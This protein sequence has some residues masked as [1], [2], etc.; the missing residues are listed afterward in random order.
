MPIVVQNDVL[1]PALWMPGK[2]WIAYSEKGYKDNEWRLSDEAKD[3]TKLELFEVS[4]LGLKKIGEVPVIG[5]QFHLHLAANQIVLLR[6][7]K[8]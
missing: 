2:Q 8:D 5:K 1:I 7:L 6:P 3:I 4:I